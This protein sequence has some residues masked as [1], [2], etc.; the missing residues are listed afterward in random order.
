MSERISVLKKFSLF[1]PAAALVVTLGM[2]SYSGAKSPD[3]GD[4]HGDGG[5][6]KSHGVH[7][8]YTG[9][10]GPSHWG[11]L[12]ADYA[13]CGKGT[14]QSPINITRAALKDLEDITFNYKKSGLNILNNGHTVQANYAPG[15]S[16]KVGGKSY[17]LLQFHFHGPSEHTVDG[18]N[19][20]IEM[21]LV[22]KSADG[23]LAVVGVM[24]ISGPHNSAF[25]NVWAFLPHEVGS[26]DAGVL[27]DA[28]GLLPAKRGYTTYSGSLTTPPCTEGVTWLVLNDPVTMSAKQ[29]NA[30]GEIFKGN[31]RP[32]QPLNRRSLSAGSN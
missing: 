26:R 19:A 29:I 24:I 13:A 31:N 5:K 18:V 15:S 1:L 25:D 23:A 17:D 30:F 7:W 10:E 4:G 32:V 16:I 22:H 8:D 3:H 20:P 12:S 11:S 21:H 2:S 27:V 9:A 28:E 14:K 6:A